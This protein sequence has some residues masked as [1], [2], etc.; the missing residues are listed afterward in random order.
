MSKLLDKIP[1]AQHYELKDVRACG[2]DWREM[3][4]VH[5]DIP[6][7]GDLWVKCEDHES[8]LVEGWITRLKSFDATF[9][10][11]VE[12]RIFQARKEVEKLIPKP[13]CDCDGPPCYWEGDKPMYCS[14]ED[15]LKEQMNEED[16]DV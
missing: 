6:D 1:K 3:E 8:T 7:M 5:P 14:K 12:K 15:I 2:Q 10:R 9:Q 11:H 16:D 4:E 13:D